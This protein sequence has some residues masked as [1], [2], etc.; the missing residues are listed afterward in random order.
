MTH[1]AATSV[2]QESD[3]LCEGCG[4]V[5]TGLPAGARCPECG[6]P[7][8]ESAVELRSPPPWE[9]PESGG[10]LPAFITT[11]AEVLFRPTRFYR[12]LATRGTRARSA[13]FAQ[14]YLMMTSVL[15]GL[16]AWVHLDWFTS[17]RPGA[18]IGAGIP[19]PAWIALTLGAYLMLFV[20]TRLAS[21]LTT[22]EATYRGIRLPLTVVRRGLDYHAA[23]YL[24]VAV[25]AAATVITYRVI[26]MRRPALGAA[27]GDVY[28]YTLCGEVVLGAAYLFK[29]YWIGMRNMMYASR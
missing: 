14:V 25:L 19:W 1:A 26:L 9:R 27:W 5:L 2:P 7:T 23:H 6:K 16:C 18:P 13:R 28:L 11:T 3:W 8:T 20:I 4:Y 24:P 29:T 12:S 17:L 15:F 21:R 10:G 22:L